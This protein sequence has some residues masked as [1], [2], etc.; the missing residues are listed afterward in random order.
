MYSCDLCY[1]SLRYPKCFLVLLGLLSCKAYILKYISKLECVKETL[2]LRAN[3][4]YD[5]ILWIFALEW[6]SAVL[7]G[8]EKKIKSIL[9]SFI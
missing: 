4:W 3:L 1:R 9:E 6:M 2:S 7:H 8:S 5:E